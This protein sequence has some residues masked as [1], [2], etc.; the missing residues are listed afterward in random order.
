MKKRRFGSVEAVH[1]DNAKMEEQEAKSELQISRKKLIAGECKES[2][3]RLL[4]AGVSAGSLA[5]ELDGAG[6]SNRKADPLYLQISKQMARIEKACF[7][8][9]RR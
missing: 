1:L 5:A 2:L 3:V 9:R 4:S 7:N 8:R 6:V